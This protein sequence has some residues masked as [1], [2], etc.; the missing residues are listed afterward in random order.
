MPSVRTDIELE[1]LPCVDIRLDIPDIDLHRVQGEIDLNQSSVM[2]SGMDRA[3]KNHIRS[4]CN[5]ILMYLF[6]SCELFL[7][8]CTFSIK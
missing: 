4:Y 2:G 7:F 8:I 1:L 5:S 3:E 6:Y